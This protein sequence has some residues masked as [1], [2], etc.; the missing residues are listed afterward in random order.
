MVRV[1]DDEGGA[2]GGGAAG[3]SGVKRDGSLT[4][5]ASSTGS[6]TLPVRQR[7]FSNL[8]STSAAT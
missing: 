4:G 2:G 5:V 3:A 1:F 7:T 8:A 6:M